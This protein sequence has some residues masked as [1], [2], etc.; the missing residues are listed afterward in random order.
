VLDAHLLESHVDTVARVER[1]RYEKRCN[2][3]NEVSY[4]I[5][6]SITHDLQKAF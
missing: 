5:L 2:E 6:V 3:F 4:L 1:G